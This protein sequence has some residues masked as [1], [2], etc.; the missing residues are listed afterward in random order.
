MPNA[1]HESTLWHDPVVAEVREVRRRLFAESGNDMSEF[2]RR[3]R[4]HQS[5]AGHEIIA[6]PESPVRSDAEILGGAPVFA[7]T[8]VPVRALFDY[9]EHGRPLAAFLD[10]FP[11][12]SKDQAT[13]VL[14]RARQFVT[15]AQVPI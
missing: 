10:D 9:L 11:T 12:V 3:L 8:R 14:K 13:E 6:P 4:A 7:G 2:F 1:D 5:A 15:A